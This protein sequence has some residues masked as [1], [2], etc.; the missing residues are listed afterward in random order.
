MQVTL[1]ART[2]VRVFERDNVFSS[3]KVHRLSCNST[4]Y[5]QM[6]LRYVQELEPA[7]S[8]RRDVSKQ[9]LLCIFILIYC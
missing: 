8:T 4:L 1:K 2:K 3:G 7:S 6:V 9:H 5:W